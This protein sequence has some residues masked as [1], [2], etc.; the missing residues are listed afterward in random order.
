MKA[1]VTARVIIKRHERKGLSLIELLVI[2]AI[3]SLLSAI[4]LPVFVGGAIRAA[5]KYVQAVHIQQ[6]RFRTWASGMFVF[7]LVASLLSSICSPISAFPPSY[8]IAKTLIL[9]IVIASMIILIIIM[10]LAV[11]SQSSSS[12]KHPWSA[13]WLLH[14]LLPRKDREELIGDLLEEYQQVFERCGKKKWRAD[15][16][17]WSQ[18]IGSAWPYLKRLAWVSAGSQLLEWFHKLIK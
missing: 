5:K 13:E 3:T 1:S 10:L 7:V 2:V 14:C 12:P 16:F 15:L 6:V 18:V 4:L 17:L 8:V 11:A 9:A